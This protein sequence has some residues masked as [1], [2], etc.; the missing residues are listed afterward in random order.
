MF[1]CVWVACVPHVIC[2]RHCVICVCVLVV[3]EVVDNYKI[4][5]LSAT[6]ASLTGAPDQ[7]CFHVML[8]N[9]PVFFAAF[10][11][12]VNLIGSRQALGPL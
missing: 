10:T 2:V 6:V 9:H 1:V 8:R 4:Q 12:T 5:R 3:T 11:S 7:S